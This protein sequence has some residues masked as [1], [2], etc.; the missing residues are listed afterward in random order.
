MTNAGFFFLIFFFIFKKN[1]IFVDNV[2]LHIPLVYLKEKALE[3]VGPEIQKKLTLERQG[4]GPWTVAVHI[5]E[6]EYC[7]LFGAYTGIL[8]TTKALA[9]ALGDCTSKKVH[10][11]LVA[12]I[13]PTLSYKYDKKKEQT[14]ITLWYITYNANGAAQWRFEGMP[15]I[16]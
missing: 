9:S 6:Y 3:K 14:V 11:G 1:K 12:H 8:S 16:E 10:A 4:S 15:Q 5:W 2:H 7:V 13:I